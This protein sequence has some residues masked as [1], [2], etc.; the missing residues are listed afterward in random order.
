MLASCDSDDKP[1]LCSIDYSFDLEQDK[2]LSNHIFHRFCYAIVFGFLLLYQSMV[3]FGR[4]L[5]SITKVVVPRT[6]KIAS[7]V[8]SG[9]RTWATTIECMST[10]GEVFKPFVVFAGATIM[11]SWAKAYPEA[12]FGCST[13]GWSDNELG[14][15]W[16]KEVFEPQTRRYGNPRLL[17]IDGHQSHISVKF[18]KFCWDHGIIPLCLPPHSTHYLQPLDV[19]LFGPLSTAYSKLLDKRNKVGLC[20]VDKIEFLAMLRMARSESFSTANIMAA[21]AEAGETRN[22]FFGVFC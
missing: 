16:V 22:F 10:R 4:L 7:S 5:T 17:I 11:K 3:N 20:F 9:D 13:N 15:L 18:V 19:G 2:H 6:N 8:Q 14:F 1:T 21:W 12:F